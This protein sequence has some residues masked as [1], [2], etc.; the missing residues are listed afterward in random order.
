VLQ[1]VG[2]RVSDA[3]QPHWFVEKFYVVRGNQMNAFSAPGGYVFVNEGLLRQADNVPELANVLAHETAHLVLGHVNAQVKAQNRKA[4][5]LNVGKG[6]SKMFGSGSRTATRS[7][8]AATLASNYGFLN[9][10][11]Q[12]EFAADKLGIR[13][14]AKAGYD[15][16]GSVWFLQESS[17]LYGDAGYESYVQHHPTIHERIKQIESYFKADPRTYRRWSSRMP[18]ATGLPSSD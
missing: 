18:A 14:A 3:A 10:S 9:F 12:Q 5:I 4:A 7:L 1:S 16:W 15:P 8:D 2:R 11:R 17:R 6:L 13:L